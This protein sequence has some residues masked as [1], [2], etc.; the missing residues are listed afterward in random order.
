M[1]CWSKAILARRS[2]QEDS[3]QH[4]KA[5]FS[6]SHVGYMSEGFAASCFVRDGRVRVGEESCHVHTLL[7]D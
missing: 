5:D 4:I 6:T 2:F 3:W 1:T 7:L